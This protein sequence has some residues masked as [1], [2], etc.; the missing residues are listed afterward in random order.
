MARRIDGPNQ[1]ELDDRVSVSEVSKVP[2][3]FTKGRHLVRFDRVERLVHWTIAALFGVLAVTGSALYFGSLFGVVLNRHTIQWIHLWAGLLLPVPLVAGAV[4]P[5]GRRVRHDVHRFV[6]WRAGELRW[7]LTA[8]RARVKFG[9][10]NP[11]QKLNAVLAGGLL[12]V[13]YVSGAMLQWFRFF[14]V[15]TR[16]AATFVHDSFALVVLVLISGHIL[17]ALAHPQALRSM[18]TGTVSEKWVGKHAPLWSKEEL[19]DDAVMN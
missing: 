9:K 17:M 6:N 4:G 5:W 14:S 10:F 18:F 7:I 8:G 3:P 11:G 12:T 1:F 19:S 2:V 16:V 13:L 15:S